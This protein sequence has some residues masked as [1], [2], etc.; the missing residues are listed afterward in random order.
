M[1]IPL[2]Q[3]R[4]IGHACTKNYSSSLFS[5]NTQSQPFW[6]AREEKSFIRC[7]LQEIDFTFRENFQSALK[8]SCC[9]LETDWSQRS[10]ADV[11]KS[12]SRTFPSTSQKVSPRRF[13]QHI[14][15]HHVSIHS[16]QATRRQPAERCH[17]SAG[18]PCTASG[19]YSNNIWLCA[20]HSD[21]CI[22]L[23]ICPAWR[24]LPAN[25]GYF[26]LGRHVS[27]DLL[28]TFLGLLLLFCNSEAE[29]T[30][31][32]WMTWSYFTHF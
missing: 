20:Y 3:S 26:F 21:I 15:I 13:Q 6:R 17:L 27:C 9:L 14:C 2:I 25:V 12:H 4:D 18:T 11:L 5:I 28:H 1:D 10:P 19:F 30:D 8:C 16:K 31:P 32:R 7:P 22:L 24:D 29:K 23:L